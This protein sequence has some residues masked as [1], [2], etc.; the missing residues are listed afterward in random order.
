MVRRRKI[1]IAEDHKIL[2]EGLKS[3]LGT[4]EDLE[5]IGEAE[6]GIEAIRCVEE[7]KPDLLLLD[8]SMPRMNGI[9]VTRDLKSR[10]PEVKILVLT[11]YDTEDYILEAF[12]SGVDG[13]CLKDANHSELLS[14]IRSVLDGKKYLS[15]TISEK[16]MAGFLD[17]RKTFKQRSSWDTLTQREREVV[18]LVGEGYKN[19]EISDFLCI[20]VKTVEKHRSN[21]MR[22]LDVHTS[23]AITAI[24]I[25][26]GLVTRSASN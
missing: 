24:A 10:L 21:I 14:A 20:S 9:S 16:V 15:P 25:D 19:K 1:V 12:R 3:L 4:V 17:E 26:K 22:K 11:I 23:S 6:D 2:R 13:Y 5:V 7:R 8:L 18:K